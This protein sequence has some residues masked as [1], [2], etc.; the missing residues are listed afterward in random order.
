V[1]KRVVAA[2]Q[3]VHDIINEEVNDRNGSFV[4]E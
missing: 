4:K 2:Y 3:E 1:A